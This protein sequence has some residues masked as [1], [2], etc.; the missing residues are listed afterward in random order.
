MRGPAFPAA[1]VDWQGR[2]ADA[3][4]YGR[5]HYGRDRK[6]RNFNGNFKFKFRL[7]VVAPRARNAAGRPCHFRLP[8]TETANST[9]IQASLHQ[10]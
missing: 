4:H 1:R 9:R 3:R 10:N 2:G 5:N 7:G 6:V 8:R